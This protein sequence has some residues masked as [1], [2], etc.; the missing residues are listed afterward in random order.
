MVRVGERLGRVAVRAV[1]GVDDRHAGHLGGHK[2]R[3]LD[4]VAHRDDVGEAAHHADGVLHRLALADGRILR[5]GETEDVAAELH[6]RGREGQARAG[7]GFVE[8]RGELLVGHA[9]LV[10]LAV[11]DDVFGQGYNLVDFLL[12]EVGRIDEV[13]HKLLR[14]CRI[15][16]F[17][18]GVM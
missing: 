2:R 14:N 1:A 3:A 8:E 4:G 16:S 6:H 17:W 5:I 18:A 11:G 13:F 9:A 15:C 7:A 12:G 10:A